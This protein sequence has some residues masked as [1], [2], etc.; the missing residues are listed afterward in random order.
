MTRL[1]FVLVLL[2]LEGMVAVDPAGAQDSTA[3]PDTAQVGHEDAWNEIATRN[4]LEF[5]YIFYREADN[6][7]E[8]VVLRL[9]N[10]N[11]YPVRYWFTV[12]FRGPDG[13]V[14]DR[15]EG[16]IGGGVMQTGDEDGLF[17][18]PF[19]GASIGEVGLRG[20]YVRSMPS[21]SSGVQSWR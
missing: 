19:E 7:D 2:L 11:E 8:G 1:F 15:V 21:D 18:V 13:E 5:S 6:K 16:Q 3:A 10:R 17:W 12:I 4:G 14:E 20:V 9:Q